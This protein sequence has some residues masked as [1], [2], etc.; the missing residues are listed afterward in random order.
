MKLVNTHHHTNSSSSLLRLDM[1]PRGVLLAVAILSLPATAFQPP[2][3]RTPTKQKRRS[4]SSLLQYRYRHTT[5]TVDD[6][7]MHQPILM[8]L[9]NGH[10]AATEGTVVS[11]SASSFLQMMAAQDNDMSAMD[12]YLEYVNKRYERMHPHQTSLSSSSSPVAAATVHI[13]AITSTNEDEEA[14]LKTLGISRLASAQLRHRLR[15]QH[16]E[17]TLIARYVSRLL[18]PL[19]YVFGAFVVVTSFIRGNAA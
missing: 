3:A 9:A 19:S 1:I 16:D 13:S 4:G 7:A 14:P 6:D 8:Q 17:S 10:L 2:A 18:K 11:S 15:K 12:E 5:A